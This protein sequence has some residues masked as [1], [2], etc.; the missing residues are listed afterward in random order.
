MIVM[1]NDLDDI[2]NIND[3][4]AVYNWVY[5]ALLPES[6]RTGMVEAAKAPMSWTDIEDQADKITPS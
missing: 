3:R 2:N 4:L 1:R 6:E 5:W